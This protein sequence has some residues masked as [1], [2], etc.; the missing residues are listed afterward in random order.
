[1]KQPSIAVLGGDLRQ[2]HLANALAGSGAQVHAHLLDGEIGLL[3]QVT[4]G[5]TLEETL[6]NAAVVILPLPCTADGKQVNAPFGRRPLPLETCLS[7]MAPGALLL[8]GRLPKDLCVQAA[9]RGIQAADYFDREELAVCNAV[10]TAE[11]AVQILLEELPVT[12]FGS[13]CLVIGYGRVGRVTAKLLTNMGAHVTVC[14][15]SVAQRAWAKVDGCSPLPLEALEQAAKGVD[16]VLNTVPTLLVDRQVLAQLDPD[17]LVMDLA[18]KPG[19]VDRAAAA[20][21]GIPV[22]WAL[23]LPGKVAPKTAGEI[24]CETI[25]NILTE[26]GVL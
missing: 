26:K 24:L 14:A 4:Q 2:V 5:Q 1:M 10:P 15:R 25:Q 13:R 22:H 23:A 6:K 11:G 20:D 19:G 21:L 9:Q 8:G 18:S 16:A 7:L 17:T 3:P 12:I